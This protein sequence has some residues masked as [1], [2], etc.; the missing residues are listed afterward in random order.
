MYHNSRQD[1][2]SRPA[3]RTQSRDYRPSDYPPLSKGTESRY[4]ETREVDRDYNYDYAAARR[5]A[6]STNVKA[7]SAIGVDG[8]YNYDYAAARRHALSTNVK[9]SSANPKIS[10]SSKRSGRTSR[11]DSHLRAETTKTDNLINDFARAQTDS[12]HEY[13]KSIDGETNGEWSDWFHDK[14]KQFME[15]GKKAAEGAGLWAPKHKDS[16][17]H[18]GDEDDLDD[19]HYQASSVK[20]RAQLEPGEIPRGSTT[21]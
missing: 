1:G 21:R 16:A 15:H 5:H 17:V 4:K 11:M 13:V 6:L 8:D 20:G 10:L 9:A 14:R 2:V 12:L 18:R 19:R 3:G 7:S